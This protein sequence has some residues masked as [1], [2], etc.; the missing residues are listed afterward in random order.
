MAT[1][2]N[3]VAASGGDDSAKLQHHFHHWLHHSEML[4]RLIFARCRHCDEF[5]PRDRFLRAGFRFFA[6]V[7]VAAFVA[8]IFALASKPSIRATYACLP[9]NA[10]GLPGRTY[11][12]TNSSRQEKRRSTLA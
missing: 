8:D 10:M 12:A 3:R 2:Y 9:S 11:I 6:V 1:V 7:F 4:Q 5:L